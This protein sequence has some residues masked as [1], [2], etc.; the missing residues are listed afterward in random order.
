M[1][2]RDRNA[3]SG[4]VKKFTID[5]VTL[6]ISSTMNRLHTQTWWC[7]QDHTIVY[8]AE[9]CVPYFLMQRVFKYFIKR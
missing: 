1:T 8:K 3:N 2:A 6:L 4:T 9:I 5:E 7:Y